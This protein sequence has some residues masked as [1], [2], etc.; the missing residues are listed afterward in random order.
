MFKMIVYIKWKSN[1]ICKSHTRHCDISNCLCFIE[2]N[3]T[4]FDCSLMATFHLVEQKLFFDQSQWFFNWKCGKLNNNFPH[5]YFWNFFWG[6]V[7]FFFQSKLMTFFFFFLLHMT[8]TQTFINLKHMF[9]FSFW[10]ISFWGRC[11]LCRTVLG[12]FCF[13]SL[14]VSASVYLSVCVCVCVSNYWLTKCVSRS[15]RTHPFVLEVFF[16]IF[17]STV[18]L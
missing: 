16:S 1:E 4:G 3:P 10:K 14:S 11:H 12:C 2:R 6:E 9:H 18:W 13:I 17:F 8:D 5:L 15:Q 7:Y